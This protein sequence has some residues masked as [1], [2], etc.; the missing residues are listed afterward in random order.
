MAETFHNLRGG[1]HPLFWPILW[2]NLVLFYARN[3]ETSAWFII[4]T[5]WSGAVRIC[6]VY[7]D[8]EATWQDEIWAAVDRVRPKGNGRLIMPPSQQIVRTAKPAGK[9]P[10]ALLSILGGAVR[11][12]LPLVFDSS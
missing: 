10:L 11:T 5:S 3:A 7:P 6:E 4:E 8:P 1:V 12:A 2:L 9:L